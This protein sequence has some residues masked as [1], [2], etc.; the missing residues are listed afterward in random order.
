[1]AGTK[2]LFLKG[3]SARWNTK[4]CGLYDGATSLYIVTVLGVERGF[5]CGQGIHQIDIRTESTA[6]ILVHGFQRKR[7]VFDPV[8][9]STEYQSIID[10]MEEQ[11]KATETPVNTSE[12]SAAPIAAPVDPQLGR[13]IE[14]RIVMN[15][16]LECEQEKKSG[17]GGIFT[18]C[19][20][21]WIY[22]VYISEIHS[23]TYEW[24]VESTFTE[25]YIALKVLRHFKAVRPEE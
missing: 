19:K 17:G 14:D 25:L 12:T 23:S 8:H 21:D 24:Y 5:I 20:W 13:K 1:M 15:Y 3:T 18:G 10:Y 22:Y 6:G 9:Y 7:F 2:K 16:L 11:E 4:Y